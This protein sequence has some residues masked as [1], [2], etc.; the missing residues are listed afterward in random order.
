M[1]F[2]LDLLL[3][4]KSTWKLSACCLK[5]EIQFLQ[6]IYVNGAYYDFCS[7]TEKKLGIVPTIL[8]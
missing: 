4:Q 2:N 7:I 5:E 6:P 3:I 1:L 8:V